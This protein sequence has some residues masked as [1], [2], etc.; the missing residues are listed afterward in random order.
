MSKDLAKRTSKFVIVGIILS[1]FNFA[2]Y[3]F[4]ARVIFQNNQLL[5]VC[6]IIAYLLAAILAYI[7][8]SK[9]TWKE[10]P[11]TKHGIIMFFVWNGITAIIISPFFTWLFGLITP[12]YQLAH[13]LTSGIGLPFDYNFIESTGIYVLTTAVAMVLNFIFYDRLVFGENPGIK[14]T[15]ITKKHRNKIFA[16][17]LYSLPVIFFI[18]SFFLITTSGEDIFQGANSLRT[19]ATLNPIG[20]AINAF[21]YNSR[22]TDMYAWSVIDFFDYQFSFGPD[23]IFRTIDVLLASAVF[24]FATYI[25]LD[26]KPKLAL[27][28]ALIYCGIFVIFIVTPFGRNFYLEFSMIHNYIP[29]AL[30]TLLFSIPYLKLV[31]NQKPTKHQ[32]LFNFLMPLLGLY[33]GMAAT[34]TPLAFIATVAIYYIIRR[35]SLSR[36]PLWFFTG[37]AGTIIGFLICWLAGSGVDHYTSTATA[38]TFDYV[39][40][41]SI[42]EAPLASIPKLLWHEIYNFSITLLPLLALFAVCYFVSKPKIKFKKLILKNQNLILIFCLFI[43][44]HILGASLIKAPFRLLIPAYLAGIIL[45]AKLF[46]DRINS[47]I[48]YGAIVIAT[49][50]IVIIH[51]ALL[52]NYHQKAAVVFDEIKASPESSLC[53]DRSRTLPARIPIIDLSQA[54][55][56]VD[57][58][59]PEPIFGKN[60]T[61]CKE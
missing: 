14:I 42:F 25:V 16:A 20:D 52:I 60:I 55:Y 59:Y 40:L 30:I 47:K 49:L 37:L 4:L 33:F 54:N 51:T 8:H 18:V 53:I 38:S 17:I 22:I 43:I 23:I 50:A 7:L 34:I 39:S 28:D 44:I 29:L 31:T 11:V 61:F 19:G 45:I 32:K 15:K 13:G 10:R 6:S 12:L 3:T 9:I 21:H 5:W 2:I 35:K 26:R 57:W 1:I 48:I 58:G 46:V 36:P 24:Y 41:S 56:L 27:K